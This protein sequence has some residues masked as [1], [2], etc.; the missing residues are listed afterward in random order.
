MKSA[1]ITLLSSG[2]LCRNPRVLKEATTLGGAGHDVT[3]ATIAW[4]PRFE[5]TD[6]ALLRD[7]PFRKAALDRTGRTAGSRTTS[8][9]ERGLTFALRRARAAHPASLGSYHA[10]RRLALARPFD[11]LIAH[12]ELPL[13]IA[14]ELLAAGLPVAADIEDWHSRD[15]L[16]DARRARPLALLETAERHLLRGAR[17]V[18]TTSRA[19]ADALAQAYD[20]PAPVV[21][22]NTFPLTPHG[23]LSIPAPPTEPVRFVWLSQT[24]GPGRGLEEFLAGWSLTRRDSRVV[25][26]GDPRAGYIETLRARLPDSHRARV[27]TAP[28]V[29]PN[30]I[31]SFLSRHDVGLA[32][33]PREPD[34]KN[35][36][37]SNKIF[38]YLDAGL[39][40]LATPTRGQSEVFARDPAIG[41]LDDL[42]SSSALAARLDD[43][44]ANRE[45]LR[46][47]GRAARR[48]AENEFCWEK[49]APVLLAT[50]E[51]S[52]AYKPPS[53]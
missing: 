21:V 27:E 22:P 51:R 1:R 45:H 8:F 53:R 37:I 5:A 28:R 38:H 9:L 15:L 29:P 30:E 36:T 17:H 35:L 47:A 3:V 32:L 23:Q 12:T 42:A 26:L 2:P 7:A 33:E 13:C 31:A 52:L 50:V 25:L 34:N 39:A 41:L 10:L 43:W 11:L 18:T 24:I 16:P 14:R 49:T 40:V 48:L 46:A 19:M 6:A 20:A 44:L 4:H